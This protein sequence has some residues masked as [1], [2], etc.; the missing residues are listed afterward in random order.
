MSRTKSTAVAE[1]Q[2]TAVAD[3]EPNVEKP[4]LELTARE[5]TVFEKYREIH[6]NKAT[7]ATRMKRVTDTDRAQLVPAHGEEFIGKLLLADALG[8]ADL[9]FSDGLIS[10]LANAAA[11]DNKVDVK[12]LNFMLSVVKSIKPRDQLESMLATQMAGIHTATMRMMERLANADDTARLDSAE[13]ALNKLARTFAAQIEA[14][15]RYRTGGDQ[16]VTVQNVSVSDGGQ[17]IVGNVTQA[18]RETAAEQVA[19]TALQLT[20][21]KQAPMTILGAEANE[22]TAVA[23]PRRGVRSDGKSSA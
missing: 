2:P 20:H 23:V 12:A 10:Q 6:T 13:R 1:Q 3:K 11:K 19:K 8:A 15:K 4:A 18:S 22:A 9:D 5:R 16:S 17:A 21:A 14:L 7:A